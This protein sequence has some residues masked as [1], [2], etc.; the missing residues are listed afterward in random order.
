MQM[1]SKM[2]PQHRRFT[3]EVVA[4]AQHCRKLPVIVC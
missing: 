2:D 3:P 4:A 1:E